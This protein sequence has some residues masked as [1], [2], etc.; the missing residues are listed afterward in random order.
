MKEKFYVERA[1]NYSIGGLFSDVLVWKVASEQFD[2]YEDAEN[3][4]KANQD[5]EHMYRIQK[6]FV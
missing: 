5:F 1:A 3:Y 6:V 4:I 2:S